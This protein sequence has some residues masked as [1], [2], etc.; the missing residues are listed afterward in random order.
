MAR[1]RRYPA[2][3]RKGRAPLNLLILSLKAVDALHV[4]SKLWNNH[5]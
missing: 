5:T 3:L 1:G 4:R 2:Q